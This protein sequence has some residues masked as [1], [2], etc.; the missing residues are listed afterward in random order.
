MV[1]EYTLIMSLFDEDDGAFYFAVSR[2]LGMCTIIV[3][4]LICGLECHRWELKDGID[5]YGI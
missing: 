3:M 4:D 1:D 2:V 5:G